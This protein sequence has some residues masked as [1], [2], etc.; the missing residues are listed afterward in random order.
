MK[1]SVCIIAARGGS[2]RIKNK[3]IKNFFGKPIIHYSINAAKNS[4]CFDK[5]VVSTD[6]NKIAQIAN[7]LG[8]ITPFLR[9]KELSHDKALL[10]P[11]IKHALKEYL[12]IDE[13][14]R[15]VCCIVPT[16]PL[17]NKKDLI[18]GFKL[19]KKK[20]KKIVLAVTEYDYPTQRSLRLNQ[21]GKLSMNFPKYRFSM[22]QDLKTFYHDAGQFYWAKKDAIIKNI[23]TLGNNTYP[24]IIP[25]ERAVDIDDISDWKKAEFAYQSLKN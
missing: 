10:R 16:A 2:K 24:I 13:N 23:P 7:K 6:N 18:M 1:H 21:N 22:S 9:P 8:A 12:K 15:Y 19:I 5:I 4:K 20:E 25:K 11:V 3:N 17:I 14:V